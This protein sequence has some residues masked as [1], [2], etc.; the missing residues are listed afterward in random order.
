[1]L[2]LCAGGGEDNTWL[3]IVEL[4]DVVAGT[5]LN[6]YLNLFTPGQ[7]ERSGY[8]DCDMTLICRKA[9]WLS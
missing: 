8:D 9:Q 1:M 2:E 4:C 7:L 6:L 3:G 5:L